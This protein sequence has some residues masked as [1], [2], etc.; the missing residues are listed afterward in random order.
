MMLPHLAIADADALIAMGKTKKEVYRD[1]AMAY[2]LMGNLSKAVEEY[3]AWIAKEPDALWAYSR[4]AELYL[5]MGQRQSAQK[6]LRT[7]LRKAPSD[8]SMRRRLETLLPFQARDYYQLGMLQLEHQKNLLA[9]I[10]FTDCLRLDPN[11]LPCSLNRGKVLALARNSDLALQD[12]NRVVARASELGEQAFVPYLMR[13]FLYAYL[14]QNQQAID[15][16]HQVLRINPDVQEA[17]KLLLKLGV[18]P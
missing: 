14:G 1:R 18:Q 3:S 16:L 17:R 6:D 9:M 4:R 15:D 10:S 5:E 7:L 11:A 2:E 8:A 12:Y 13:G